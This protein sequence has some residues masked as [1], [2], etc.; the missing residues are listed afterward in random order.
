M[1]VVSANEIGLAGYKTYLNFLKEN[2]AKINH[3]NADKLLS[4]PS[5]C[6]YFSL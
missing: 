3:V 4:L 2:S 5:K 1:G 6:D